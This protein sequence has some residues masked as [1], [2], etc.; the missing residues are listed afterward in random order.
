MRTGA[1]F[2]A[3]LWALYCARYPCRKSLRAYLVAALVVNIGTEVSLF[4]FGETARAYAILYACFTA[5]G[6][7]AAL[8]VARDCLA[9]RWHVL[10]GAAAAL[11]V[12]LRAYAGLAK[13][14]HFYD[15]FALAEG[16][17]LTLAGTALLFSA[18]HH[19]RPKIWLTLGVLWIVQA[20]VRVGFVLSLPSPT[21]LNLN[22]WLPTVL[23]VGA[24]GFL[25][26]QLKE[27]GLAVSTQ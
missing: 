14:L 8:N 21:W 12:V 17:A 2:A 25:G 7:L 18:A 19:E 23:V 16:A 27:G 6:L 10:A 20:C 4:A 15:W 11:L 22:D 26:M 3:I 5:I 1:L 13:P 24:Y 9:K